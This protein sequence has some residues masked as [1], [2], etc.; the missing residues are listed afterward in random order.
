MVKGAGPDGRGRLDEGTTPLPDSG[1]A[2][3]SNVP[4]SSHRS[5]SD[6]APR[7]VTCAFNLSVFARVGGC[8]DATSLLAC[9]GTEVLEAPLI[10][11][12]A[13]VAR[14]CR[15]TGAKA[16]VGSSLR[17]KFNSLATAV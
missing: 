10:L 2:M 14:F 17:N 3:V 7:P 15:A 8:S 12:R 5:L 16:L 11:W 6:D 9:S 1:A 13:R 4:Q